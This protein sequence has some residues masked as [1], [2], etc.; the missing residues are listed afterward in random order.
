MNEVKDTINPLI[1]SSIF[2]YEFVFR[3]PFHDGNGITARL[4]QTVILSHWEKVLDIYNLN[5][6][7]NFYKENKSKY[8][9]IDEYNIEFTL[10][11]FLKEINFK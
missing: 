7:I 8:I 6:F 9:I 1:L 4:W 3:H 10:D 11:E 2:H 5:H